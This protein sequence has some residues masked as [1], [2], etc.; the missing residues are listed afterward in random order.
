MSLQSTYT[1]IVEIGAGGGGTVFRAYHIRMQKYVVL[2]KIHE[3]IQNSVDIRGELDIL[4]NL[5]HSYLP[6]VLDFIEDNG[7]IYTV[8]D[9]I[10]GESFESMLNRGVR[11]S[12]AQVA[13]YAAQLSEV[14]AYLH[15]QKQ[16]IIHG[17]IKPANIM[18]TPEN[19]ICLIDFNISQVQSGTFSKNLGYTPGYASPEQT[20]IIYTLRQYYS[21]MQASAQVYAQTPVQMQQAQQVQPAPQGGGTVML[22]AAG[23][24]VM[25]DA[26]G[27]TVLLDAQSGAQAQG[28][29]GGTVLLNNNGGP[30]T[31]LL[32]GQQNAM[33][34]SPV[35]QSNPAA[36]LPTPAI[37][38][39]MDE[40]S[41]IYSVGATLYAMLTGKAPSA[42]FAA[43]TP[44]EE[45]VPNCSEG[46]AQIINKCMAFRPE[47]RIESAELLSKMV[48]GIAKIDKR[49]KHLVL[50]Q[51]LALIVC[52]LG[53]AGSLITVFLGKERME[54]EQIGN[55][56]QLVAEM[57]ELRIDGFLENQEDFEELYE[58]AV[59]EFPGYAGAYYQ[60]ALGLYNSRQ[61]EEMIDFI[62]KDVLSNNRDFSSEETGNFYFLLAN[63]YLETDRNDEAL[64]YYKTAVEYNPH[65]A[66][67]YSDY[68]ITLARAGKLDEAE[69]ILQKAVDK[70][71]GT[72]KVFLAKGEIESRQG[73]IE[74]AADC[75]AQC[76]EETKDNYVLLRAYV[77]WGK[78]YDTGVPTEENLKNKIAV[79]TEGLNRVEAANKAVILEQ[80]AQAYIDLAALTTSQ[81]DYRAAIN[82]L[83]QIVSLG[84]DTYVTHSN[85]GILYQ[86]IG[87]Y[88]SASAEYTEML[89][90]YGEDYRTYKRLAFLE[91]DIQAA[92]ENRDRNYMQFLEYYNKAVELF[93]DSGMQSDSDMEMQL[94]NQVY[95]QLVDGNWF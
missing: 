63:G 38:E 75:F 70:G 7:S 9:Y 23:K 59:A 80:Q 46:L 89:E 30:G 82:S 43:I 34:Q 56:N 47:K 14:L 48:S 6:T 51:Q 13:R 18:L 42:D 36:F 41:D 16:P 31:M 64:A 32:G 28:N 66:T 2:K 20:R 95:S 8:M 60:R 74:E 78:I 61:F 29:Q 45:L 72:D 39:K 55:Y 79:L 92:K 81:D 26:A 19:N 3:N 69:E 91:I 21:S 12:Q 11:F 65:D 49:Y 71:L 15:G 25:L 37:T 76:V 27:K 33:P 24:T 4:K 40:R 35:M 94:L 52:I 93:E 17:D 83:E 77:M 10:P 88:E 22:D 90:K 57:E 86:T 68:A 1:D 44:I 85:I 50:R 58:R 84:W 53:I 5:R 62:T 73:N 54:R 87:E 67:Y